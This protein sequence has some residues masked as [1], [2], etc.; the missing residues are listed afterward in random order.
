MAKN[1]IRISKTKLKLVLFISILLPLFIF[2]TN[3]LRTA[4]VVKTSIRTLAYSVQKV[5]LVG[6]Y[7]PKNWLPRRELKDQVLP[8]EGYQASVTFGDVIPKMVAAGVIDMQKL[9][10]NYKDRGGIPQDMKE[11]LSKSSQK[12][13]R[14]TKE[15]STWLIT[16]L[17]PLGLTNKMAINEKSPVAGK[18]VGNFASTGGW[19]LGKAESGA[20]YFNKYSVLSLT[21]QQEQRV[22]KLADTIHRP[23]C[24]NSAFFQDCNHGSAAL[25]LVELAVA[26][27]IPDDEIYKTVLKFNSFWFPSNYTETALY[28]QK[29]KG[30]EWDDLDPKMILSKQYSSI[31]GWMANVDIAARKTPGLLPEV[32]GGSSCAV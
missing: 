9:E 17:W 30:Q 10:D 23:C 29:V 16:L 4:P 14:I 19:T 6:K 5:P 22:R 31:S 11:L 27:N 13:I 12:P 20:E 3:Y 2:G 24:N 21:P 15:N 18:D 1:Y 26:Q 28:F 32:Q 7:I 8:P 25:G